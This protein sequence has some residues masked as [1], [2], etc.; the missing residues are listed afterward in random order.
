MRL[1]LCLCPVK[2]SLYLFLLS[3]TNK[4]Y[5]L[6]YILSSWP[7]TFAEHKT[8]MFPDEYRFFFLQ[9]FCGK[10]NEKQLSVES[11][12]SYIDVMVRQIRDSHEKKEEA[13][14]NRLRELKVTIRDMVQ[15]H[16]ALSSAYRYD[17]HE[18]SQFFLNRH[19][20][21][22]DTWW[23]SPATCFVLVN[24]T[25]KLHIHIKQSK[26]SERLWT[27]YEDTKLS[28]QKQCATT[29][30]RLLLCLHKMS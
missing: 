20:H 18:Y 10:A 6:I 28:L 17:S 14:E 29:D 13:L 25:S 11:L 23:W 2:T 12:Q 21:K 7:C 22:T 19:I 4:L 26:V 15:K 3:F 16:E 1:C 9:M 27:V 24:N 5:L 8:V 30:N